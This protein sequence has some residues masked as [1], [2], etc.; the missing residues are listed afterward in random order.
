[1]HLW[2]DAGLK[3]EDDLDAPVDLD[4]TTIV[5]GLETAAGPDAV[6][7]VLDR[8]DSSRVVLSLDLFEG[9]PRL[10]KGADWAAT[11]LEGLSRQILDL[12]GCRLLLLD[13]ACVGTGRG[14]GTGELHLRLRESR[15]AVEVSVGG[16]ISAIEELIAVRTAGAAAALVGSALHDGRL[17]RKQLDRLVEQGQSS[18]QAALNPGYLQHSADESPR[19]STSAD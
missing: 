14:T 11:G 2:I 12:G 3:D 19:H 10:T 6:R 18:R 5:V 7:A 15:P 16:G 4:H 13:L 9:V 17:G 1:M 8:T